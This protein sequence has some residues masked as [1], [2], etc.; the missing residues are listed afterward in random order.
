MKIITLSALLFTLASPAFA[1]NIT[2]A[3][4][5]PIGEKGYALQIDN[6]LIAQS[7]SILVDS[8]GDEIKSKSSLMSNLLIGRVFIPGWMF[9]V[10]VPYTQSES[11]VNQR[12][13]FG[14]VITE[15]GLS[16]EWNGWHYRALMYV[17]IPGKYDPART[18][19]VGAGAWSIGPNLSFTRYL[20]DKKY[21]VSAWAQYAVNFTNPDTQVK[22]GNIFSYAVAATA[23]IE[24]GVPMLVGVEQ[25]GLVGDPNTVDG[26]AGTNK[27][28]QQFSAGP[29]MMINLGKFMPGFTLWPTAQYDFYNRNT[30]RLSLYYLKLQYVW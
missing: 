6:R 19:N 16:D 18:L 28:K 9:R 17:N 29:V 7:A 27:A 3:A 24:A 26:S 5:P 8:K 12:S 11:G 20:A 10:S 4:H 23:Q 13:A 22:A 15:A 25:R 1:N 2:A 30:S 21:N 14:D